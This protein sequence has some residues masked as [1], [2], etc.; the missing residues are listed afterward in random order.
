MR[1]LFLVGLLG[2][3]SIA[4]PQSTPEMVEW[5]NYGND[6]ASTRY[7]PLSQIDQDTVDDLEV[8]WRW[9]VP[10][11]DIIQQTNLRSGQF[12]ATPIMVNGVLYT[13]TPMN[14]VAAIDSRNGE[15]IWL[16]DPAAYERGIPANSGFQHRGVAYWTDGADERIIIATGTRQLIAL[17]AQTGKPYDDF[18]ADGWVDLG[19][20][21][22]RE[23]KESQLG[24]N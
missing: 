17:N 15:T 8:A 10:D 16:Y 21:L 22:G 19:K 18:G 2:L 9:T 11:D 5:P 3:S 6:L 14:Q 24:F 4:R 7:S 1:Y 13:S 12:K 23:I 20:G